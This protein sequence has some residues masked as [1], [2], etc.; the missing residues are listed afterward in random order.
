MKDQKGDFWNTKLI[1][2]KTAGFNENGFP[3]KSYCSTIFSPFKI[4]KEQLSLKFC[5]ITIPN[6]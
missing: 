5:Q 4:D 2:S 1:S 3:Y 6:V